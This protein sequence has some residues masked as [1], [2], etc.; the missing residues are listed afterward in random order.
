MI[1]AREAE[2]MTLGNGEPPPTGTLSTVT[3]AFGP[4]LDRLWSRAPRS[5][6]G[7]VP[8]RPVPT[9]PDSR[10]TRPGLGLGN[11]VD[12]VRVLSSLPS[13]GEVTY[14]AWGFGVATVGALLI[15]FSRRSPRR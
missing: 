11:I 9:S 5:G 10:P 13:R 12:Y 14:F 7:L 1:N 15:A 6:G 8:T 4:V 2:T 3:K